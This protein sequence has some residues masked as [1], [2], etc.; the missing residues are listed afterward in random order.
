MGF[1]L[2]VIDIYVLADIMEYFLLYK[3]YNII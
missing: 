1:P 3:N 2:Y